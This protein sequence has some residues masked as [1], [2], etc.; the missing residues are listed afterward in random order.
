MSALSQHQETLNLLDEPLQPTKAIDTTTNKNM[1]PSLSPSSVNHLCMEV[2]LPARSSGL[3]S[4]L[5]VHLLKLMLLALRD[6]M[7]PGSQCTIPAQ[8]SVSYASNSPQ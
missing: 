3:L 5:P 2:L 1:V 7:A 4:S 8:S 6:H